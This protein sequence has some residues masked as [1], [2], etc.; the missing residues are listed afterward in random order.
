MAR[1]QIGVATENPIRLLDACDCLAY[2]SIQFTDFPNPTFATLLL[3]YG[4]LPS[5]S[6][7]F[8]R[9]FFMPRLE[10]MAEILSPPA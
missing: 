2:P 7:F 10:L 4:S 9:S 6:F 3:V 1:R 5:S 8:A